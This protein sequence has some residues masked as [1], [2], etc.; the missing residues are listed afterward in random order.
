MARGARRQPSS[1]SR[2]EA[3]PAEELW[4]THE[5]RRERLVA[6]A[7]AAPRR[8]AAAP[9]RF[10]RRR[11]TR[12]TRCSIPTRS[13]SASR[14]AS[15][16]ISGP[17]CCCAIPSGWSRILNDPQRPV[18]ILFAGK[19]HP[20]DDAGKALIQQIVKAGAAAR[21]PPARGVSGRLRHGRGALPGAGLRH[22][23]EHPAPAARGQRHQRHEG[24]GQRRCSTSARWMAGGTKP[25]RPRAPE[26]LPS[27]GPSAAARATTTPITRTRWKPAALYD[28]LEHDVVPTF[29]DRGADG[30]P[31]RW[32]AQMKSVHRDALPDLQHAARGERIHHRLS[33]WWRTR[34][35]GSSPAMDGARARAWPPGTRVS[36]PPGRRCAWSAWIRCPARCSPPEAAW[37]VRARVALGPL[38]ARRGGRGAVSRQAG[39]PL[40]RSKTPWPSPW[41]R[42]GGPDGSPHFVASE[43]PCRDSGLHGYTVRVLPFHPD[44]AE[45]FLPGL[46]RWADGGAGAATA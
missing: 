14:A 37:T 28:L 44:A 43:V 4:R 41:K 8:P 18:Q 45:T 40:R 26:A 6:F 16:P 5:R 24:P 9:R 15:P 21:I 22:L 19:A 33:T 31:R 3:I 17:R 25:G 27:A 30:L 12:P 1:G 42:R 23:A 34:A 20:R 39:R 13:P 32:I 11:S 10:A 35:T 29:Y 2:V 36:A 38:S 7:R 46:I